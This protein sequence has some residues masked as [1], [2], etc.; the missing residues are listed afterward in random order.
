MEAA[1]H[2]ALLLQASDLRDQT[3]AWLTSMKPRLL[4]AA[5]WMAAPENA[6]PGLAQDEAF[7]D[8]LF[9]DAD[10]LGETGVLLHNDTL[11]KAARGYVRGGA[12]RQDSSGF[13]SENGGSDTSYQALS[14]LYAMTYYSLAANEDLRQQLYPKIAWGLA[15][16]ESRTRPDGTVDQTGNTRTGVG[17]DHRAATMDY[18][19]A[20]HAA[21]DWHMITG[22]EHWA[23]CAQQLYAARSAELEQKTALGR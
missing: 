5:L 18:P 21:Y 2:A 3:Q 7:A 13:F 9:L 16:L 11:M 14:L 10:A 19:A 8:R 4:K 20:Y 6:G 1:A 23:K 22:D 15:W 12:A 17:R